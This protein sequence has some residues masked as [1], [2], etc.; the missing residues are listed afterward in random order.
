M[1]EEREGTYWLAFGGSEERH[2]KMMRFCCKHFV[3]VVNEKINLMLVFVFLFCVP[4]LPPCDAHLP[5]GA[6]LVITM[7]NKL[8]LIHQ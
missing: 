6:L 8:F 2:G 3:L 5:F 4:T 1:E 7:K